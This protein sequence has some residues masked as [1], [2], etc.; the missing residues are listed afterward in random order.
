MKPQFLTVRQ[1]MTALPQHP[2]IAYAVLSHKSAFPQF[3]SGKIFNNHGIIPF[4][5][6][7]RNGSSFA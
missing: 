6:I 2:P 4:Y 5:A 7:H 3:S 1:F